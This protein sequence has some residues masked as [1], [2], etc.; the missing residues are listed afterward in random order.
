MKEI[1][2]KDSG[3]T[4]IECTV[5]ETPGICASHFELLVG[6]K[7]AEWLAKPTQWL[8]SRNAGRGNVIP[9]PKQANPCG[10]KPLL[11]AKKRTLPSDPRPFEIINDSHRL[12]TIA[13]SYQG[14]FASR[15]LWDLLGGEEG[16]S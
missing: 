5:C 4:Q 13:P 7:P 10:R 9:R 14:S 16:W 6:A 3:S 2:P 15:F 12:E 8:A 1:L 11:Q